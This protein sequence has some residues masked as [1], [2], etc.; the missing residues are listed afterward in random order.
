MC[1]S[2][3]AAVDAI[4]VTCGLSLGEYTALAFAGA[5]RCVWCVRHIALEKVSLIKA[6]HHLLANTVFAP[7]TVT[8][9]IMLTEFR[10]SACRMTCECDP[11]AGLQDQR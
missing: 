7:L 2:I 10:F 3:Q 8:Q 4:D 6:W 9:L 11:S 5:M 1:T